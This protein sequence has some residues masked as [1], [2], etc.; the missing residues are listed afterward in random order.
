MIQIYIITVSQRWFH[1]VCKVKT[2]VLIMLIVCLCQYVDN[3]A[4]SKTMNKTVNPLAQSK[5]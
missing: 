1:E 4:K 3:F 5:Q 2:I